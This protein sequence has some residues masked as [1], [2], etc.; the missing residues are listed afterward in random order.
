MSRW[1]QE[2]EDNLPPTARQC[3]TQ[4]V[5]RVKRLLSGVETDIAAPIPPGQYDSGSDEEQHFAARAAA[6]RKPT[7]KHS[8]HR[9]PRDSNGLGETHDRH[10]PIERSARASESRGGSETVSGQSERAIG[11]NRQAASSSVP[12]IPL[13]V[14]FETQ[15]GREWMSMVAQQKK[16]PATT[17]PPQSAPL[18][19]PT[20]PAPSSVAAPGQA[21]AADPVS[22]AQQVK[23]SELEQLR[24]DLQEQKR[25]YESQISALR[26]SNQEE[27][28]ALKRRCYDDM[29]FELQ[30]ATKRSN[31]QLE[32]E[33]ATMEAM[34]S[35]LQSRVDEVSLERDRR[36]AE[37]VAKDRRIAELVDANAGLQ[38]HL[39]ELQHDLSQLKEAYSK[40]TTELKRNV[41][42]LVALQSRESSTTEQLESLRGR[43]AM[44]SCA[45]A[46][47]ER[48]IQELTERLDSICKERRE[49]V[50]EFQSQQQ[51]LTKELHALSDE[52]GAEVQRLDA[53]LKRRSERIELLKSK[54]YEARDT[55]EQVRREYATKL[56]QEKE[57]IQHTCETVFSDQLKEIERKHDDDFGKLREQQTKAEAVHAEIVDSLQTKSDRCESECREATEKLQIA[58]QERDGLEEA[59]K[60]VQLEMGRLRSAV[61]A[62]DRALKEVSEEL[63]RLR[64]ELAE[65]TQRLANSEEIIGRLK[66]EARARE[67]Q[68]IRATATDPHPNMQLQAQ[69]QH[70]QELRQS[71]EAEITQ[72]KQQLQR[73][74]DRSLAGVAA[75][76]S[77]STPATPKPLPS[78]PSA[79]TAVLTAAPEVEVDQ[80]P[81]LNPS[82]EA[83]L[84][85]EEGTRASQQMEQIRKN[86][87]D[88]MAEARRLVR[89]IQRRPKELAKP[90]AKTHKKDTSGV[91]ENRSPSKDGYSSE[92]SER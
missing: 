30:E 48:K 45:L 75:S 90:A 68:L 14:Q 1:Q 39:G 66:S 41:A 24:L 53:K 20:P 38:N 87:D 58:L 21:S 81:P 22:V 47:R 63:T 34:Q 33:R 74:R 13:P 72:L 85:S 12:S 57:R 36:A 64:N 9:D 23:L 11:S 28:L 86:H 55:A 26:V 42:E 43:E 2:D 84:N 5:A 8:S 79:G 69:L 18:S 78:P 44:A 51:K 49:Q 54:V 82:G 25:D 10:R 59:A 29:H 50:E 77:G 19:Q 65:K 92:S 56:E 7:T 62:S 15:K 17:L 32:A 40:A 70:E 31:S 67:A 89:E 3:L 61:R 60:T 88:L 52:Y 37:G 91:S 71:K 4:T 76:R 27:L 83:T 80:P 73:L 46:D 35:R 6:A 16:G